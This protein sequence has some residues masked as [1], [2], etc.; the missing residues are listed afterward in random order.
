M[1]FWD[2]GLFC[3][4]IAS[5]TGPISI[6]IEVTWPSSIPT[7]VSCLRASDISGGTGRAPFRVNEHSM[8]EHEHP[9]AR[10]EHSI[11]EHEH[12]MIEHEPPMMVVEVKEKHDGKALC[13]G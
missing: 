2:T 8:I 6:G 5:V 12:P 11:T 7:L 3:R 13:K 4:A 1:T 9:V 10:H